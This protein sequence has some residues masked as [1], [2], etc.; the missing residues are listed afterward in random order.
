MGG[1]FPSKVMCFHPHSDLT[2]PLMSLLEIRAVIDA[3]AELEAELGAS[4]P[5]VQVCGD[6]GRVPVP[7]GTRGRC[8]WSPMAGSLVP[9]LCP[10]A[11]GFCSPVLLSPCAGDSIFS[12]QQGRGCCHPSPY[13][14]SSTDLREQRGDDGLLQ[15]TPALPGEAVTPG[16][17]LGQRPLEDGSAVG[18]VPFLSPLCWGPS[19]VVAACWT[20]HLVAARNRGWSAVGLALG[21]VV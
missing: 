13:T 16:A 8:C 5:W 14:A 3:W 19:L 18:S 2:L 10:C 7:G 20:A 21:A 17:T 4:Y 9:T 1:F 12:P 15:P 6:R 11:S